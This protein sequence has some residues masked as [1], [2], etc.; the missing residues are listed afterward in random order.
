MRALSKYYSSFRN[1]EMTGNT[2]NKCQS[3]ISSED[4]LEVHD[5]LTEPI[6]HCIFASERFGSL[7]YVVD[8]SAILC[9]LGEEY[10]S[11]VI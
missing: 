1:G 6:S 4:S 5:N 2:L 11:L 3:Q 9:C 10:S 7:V 8:L